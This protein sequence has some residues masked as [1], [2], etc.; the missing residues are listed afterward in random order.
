MR[1]QVSL[2]ILVGLLTIGIKE[3][4]CIISRIFQWGMLI[5]FKEIKIK[6]THYVT[7]ILGYLL[8]NS[9]HWVQ[10]IVIWRTIYNSNYVCLTIKMKF[11]KYTLNMFINSIKFME[12]SAW[13][14]FC[15][16]QRHTTSPP[17]GLGQSNM[18]ESIDTESV[19]WEW[20]QSC[21]RKTNH[22]KAKINITHISHETRQVGGETPDIFL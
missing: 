3:L 1:V 9:M 18:S 5:V 4:A 15:D 8:Q 16:K 22:W 17:R 20:R 14:F 12:F 11:S 21:F 7:R 19:K 13:N 2:A 6:V 10:N